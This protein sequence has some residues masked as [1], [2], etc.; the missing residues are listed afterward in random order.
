MQPQQ[1]EDAPGAAPDHVELLV[2]RDQVV[3]EQARRR[4]RE[5]PRRLALP[6]RRVGGE[7]K[8]D[9]AEAVVEIDTERH[10]LGNLGIAQPV[11]TDPG[12][13]RTL[14]D[15][16]SRKLRGDLVGFRKE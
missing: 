9:A 10:E 6:R 16:M 11:E 4:L 3:T 13:A 1:A 12:R 8:R 5:L 7:K 14:A 15:G 2:R